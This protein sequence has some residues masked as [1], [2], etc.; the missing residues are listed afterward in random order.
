MAS[1]RII[2][3]LFST[4]ID[5]FLFCSLKCFTVI[6]LWKINKGGLSTENTKQSILELIG[7]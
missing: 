3:A 5:K 7:R 1:V 6:M 4:F 2:G